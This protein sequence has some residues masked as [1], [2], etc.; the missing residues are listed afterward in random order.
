MKK[1]LNKDN[2][3]VAKAFSAVELTLFCNNE[4]DGVKEE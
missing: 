4:A 2:H 1:D 3:H